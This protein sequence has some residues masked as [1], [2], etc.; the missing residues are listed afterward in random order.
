[1]EAVSVMS[2]NK[3]IGIFLVLTGAILWGLSGTVAQYLFQVKGLSPGWLIT[4][5]LTTSGLLLL[6]ISALKYKRSFLNIW[7]SKSDRFPLL[8]FALFGMLTVQYTYFVAIEASNAATA[9]FLQYLA[10]ALIAIY[11]VIVNRKLPVGKEQLALIFA[12]VG[13]FLLVTK[14]T[15]ESLSITKAALFWGITSAFALAFYTIQPRNLLKKWDSITITGWG[16][17]IGGLAISFIHPPWEF[18]GSLSVGS[19]FFILFVIVFGT[20]IPFYCYM[21][22]LNYISPSETSMLASIEP[23]TAAIVSVAWLKTSFVVMEWL[24]AAFIVATI[25]LLSNHKQ[26]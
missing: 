13:T 7:K 19:L 21:E 26:E 4:I 24:G 10:P 2:K 11:Y 3:S 20:L 6:L 22:S 14:G 5:R 8:L 1:M 25:I 9:T 12:I 15:L 18:Q 23:L 17:L 16:M